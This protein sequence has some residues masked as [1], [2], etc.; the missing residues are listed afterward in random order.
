MTETDSPLKIAES[1]LV[2]GKR[3]IIPLMGLM[4][5]QQPGTTIPQMVEQVEAEPDE[6]KRQVLFGSLLALMFDR[7]KSQSA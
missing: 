3:G 1:L 4:N 2:K 7:S 5:I 6:E